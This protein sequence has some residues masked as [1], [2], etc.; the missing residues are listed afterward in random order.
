MKVSVKLF[1]VAKEWAD[2]DAVELDLPA[3]ATVATVREALL[4]RLPKLAQFG[5]N[6]RFA[7]DTDYANDATPIS[8]TSDVA[9]IP[10]VSGG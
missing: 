7:V 4:T 10:P 9:C 2:A 5:S 8:A 6:L 3:A 1:A